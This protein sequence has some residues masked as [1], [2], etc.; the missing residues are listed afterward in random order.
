MKMPAIDLGKLP[1]PDAIETL[2]VDTL[3][4]ERI[5]ELRAAL[6]EENGSDEPWNAVLRADPL[7]K[8]QTVNS[9]RELLLRNRINEAVR[10]VLLAT[11]MEGDL[12]Q[13]SADFNLNRLEGESDDAFRARRQLA[14]EGYAVAGPEDAYR[15][16]ALSVDATIKQV[17]AVKGEDNRVT[18]VLLSREGN[19]SVNAGIVAKVHEALSPLSLRPMTDALYTRSADITET[20]VSIR[21]EIGPGPDAASVEAKALAGLQAY[22]A[23]RHAVGVTLNY[24]GLI[25]AA[26]K[27][28]PVERVTVLAPE[29]DVDPGV[30]GAV[31]VT[32]IAVEVERV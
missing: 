14:P 8:D 32:D 20:A 4:A 27:A 15:F 28:D 3:F 25:G 6:I 16:H 26:R 19:G 12:E 24:D 10:A 29:A 21:I 9:Y 1:P 13:L 22:V 30:M 31:F 18:V 17:S 23:S 7:V 5:A 2:D 11:A